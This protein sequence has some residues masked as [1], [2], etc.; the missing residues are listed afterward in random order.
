M[1]S[2]T[3]LSVLLHLASLQATATVSPN[4]AAG[5]EEWKIRMRE[6]CVRII[7]RILL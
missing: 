6:V 2:K 1:K 5:D 4:A 3:L 7:S